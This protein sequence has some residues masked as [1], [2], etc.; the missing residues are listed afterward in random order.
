MSL[1][2]WCYTMAACLLPQLCMASMLHIDP[3]GES[4][5][6]Q[7]VPYLLQANSKFE[8]V[9][10]DTPAA[11]AEE[12]ERSLALAAE[13]GALLRPAMALLEQAASLNHPVAQYRLGLIYAV[14]YPSEV[15]KE[16]ACPLFERSLAQGFAPPALNIS[17][18][19]PAF[20]D[21]SE[22]QEA[23]QAVEAS[24]SFYEKYFPQ[25]AVRLE[26]WPDEPVGLAMQWGGSRDYQ[27]EIY[28]LQGD[29]NRAQRVKYYQKALEVNDCYKAKKRLKILLSPN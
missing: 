5:Y 17:Y 14:L 4:F 8:A 7:A 29:S 13:A 6:Q 23:L 18:W 16:K 26:C 24:M 11:S 9:T 15:I 27:A 21:T 3:Q 19:C 12:K 28:R 22:Y 1:N 10:A 20:T 2:H 25:P